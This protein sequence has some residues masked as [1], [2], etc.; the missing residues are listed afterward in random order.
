MTAPDP[1]DRADE[2]ADSLARNWEFTRDIA[3]DV[4]DLK[5]RQSADDAV[6]AWR[7]WVIPLA[8]SAIAVLVAVASLLM[9]HRR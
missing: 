7:H 9:P 6:S 8:L 2:A 1:P 4:A 5:A 3:K